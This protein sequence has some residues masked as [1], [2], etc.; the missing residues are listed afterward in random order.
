M[1]TSD[2][3][4]LWQQGYFLLE[5]HHSA[6]ISPKSP[7]ISISPVID[8]FHLA[9]RYGDFSMFASAYPEP[10]KINYI[11]TELRFG[12]TMQATNSATLRI[13]RVPRY[14]RAN[15][16]P[17]ES[18]QLGFRGF[19]HTALLLPRGCSSTASYFEIL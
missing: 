9:M 5:A 1:L 14:Y 10:K 3:V 11:T 13:S 19:L 18:T 4:S 15:L 8:M 7:L 16:S 2:H 6:Y 12:I 17:A